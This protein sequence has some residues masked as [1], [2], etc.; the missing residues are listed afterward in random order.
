MRELGD[1]SGFAGEGFERI[2]WLRVGTYLLA[3]HRFVAGTVWLDSSSQ[4][5][6]LGLNTQA[7]PLF[8]S[9]AF[10]HPGPNSY[11]S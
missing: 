7:S 4:F 9:D 1:W 3:E 8:I 11:R 10:D 2:A 6:H 5:S